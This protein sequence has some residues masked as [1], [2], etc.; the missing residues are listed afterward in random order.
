MDD[1][2]CCKSC[3]HFTMN[4]Q[5]QANLCHVWDNDLA[6]AVECRQEYLDFGCEYWKPKQKK[7][8]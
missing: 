3:R 4:D 2:R 8:I 7:Q 5:L 6:P 1:V